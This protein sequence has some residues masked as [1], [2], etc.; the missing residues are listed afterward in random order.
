M[1]TLGAI[2]IV[3]LCIVLYFIALKISFWW[4]DFTEKRDNKNF[5]T[6]LSDY[7]NDKI[8]SAIKLGGLFV[9]IMITMLYLFLS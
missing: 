6:D 1:R 7:K 9:V 3:I 4:I 2:I 8:L 5:G